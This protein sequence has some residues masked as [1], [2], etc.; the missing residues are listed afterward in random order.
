MDFGGASDDGVGE[1]VLDHFVWLSAFIRIR[2]C[3][4]MGCSGWVA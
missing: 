2:I 3:R 1:F 4:I